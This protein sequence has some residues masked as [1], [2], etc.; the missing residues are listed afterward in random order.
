[1]GTGMAKSITR[2]IEVRLKENPDTDKS[3]AGFQLV[4]LSL[5]AVKSHLRSDGK[6]GKRRLSAFH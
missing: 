2:A 1:M 5:I 3:Q 6:T 4:H